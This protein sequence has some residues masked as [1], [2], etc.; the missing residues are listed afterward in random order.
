MILKIWILFALNDLN[1]RF[2]EGDPR[3]DS[4]MKGAGQYFHTNNEDGKKFEL[5]YVKSRLSPIN[6]YFHIKNMFGDD[7]DEWLFPDFSIENR[8]YPVLL[9]G[10]CWFFGIWLSRGLR[11][12]SIAAGIP[13]MIAVAANGAIMLPSAVCL[14][15]I[16][17]LLLRETLTDMLFYMNYGQI[18]L[19]R[20]FIFY[21]AS[22]VLAL[23]VNFYATAANGFSVLPHIISVVADCVFI[24]M[25][26]SIKSQK[27]RMQEHRLFFPV[28]IV[29][30]DS[31]EK[32]LK[33]LPETAAA[34]VAVIMIPMFILFFRNSSP[35]E[36]PVQEIPESFNSWSWESLDYIDKTYEGLVNAA[37]LITHNAYQLGFLY[38]REYTFPQKDEKLTVPNYVAVNNE[39]HYRDVFILQFTDEWY[40]SII[41]PELST[42]LAALLTSQKSPGGISLKSD[43]S[44]A[45]SSFN[46]ARHLIIS[47]IAVLPILGQFLIRVRIS[48]RRKGQEA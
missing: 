7:S 27:V 26:Y 40:Q 41:R 42:G 18:R 21:S 32:N 28:S 20:N 12:P 14:Y 37:D 11:L 4:F 48:V 35:V 15:I 6:F 45:M 33:K 19:G 44:D 2:V 31:P 43:I 34:V 13:W 29:S 24:F 16:I 8:I 10:I 3:V 9:F 46:P 22:F 39:I 25:F 30:D 38:G 47:L 36:V 17:A 23:I 1:D 5:I